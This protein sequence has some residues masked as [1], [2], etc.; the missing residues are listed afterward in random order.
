MNDHIYHREEEPETDNE[1]ENDS[2]SE[3]EADYDEKT[4]YNDNRIHNELENLV[5]AIKSG[6]IEPSEEKFKHSGSLST[7][8]TGQS[9]ST[10]ECILHFLVKETVRSSER[11]RMAQAIRCIAHYQPQLLTVYSEARQTALYLA[12]ENMNTHRAHVILYGLLKREKMEPRLRRKDLQEAIGKKCGPND[13]N[14]LH[15]ALR[16]SPLQINLGILERL[17]SFAPATAINATDSTGI[18]PLHRAVKYELSSAKML[19]IIRNLLKRGEADSEKGDADARRYAFDA[20]YNVGTESLSAYEYH[21]KTRDEFLFKR[22]EPPI[23]PKEKIYKQREPPKSSISIQDGLQWNDGQSR[24]NEEAKN[25]SSGQSKN[26]RSSVKRDNIHQS[27]NVPS[28]EANGQKDDTPDLGIQRS[29]TG[30][31]TPSVPPAAEKSG[32]TERPKHSAG[33]PDEGD[34]KKWSEEICKALKLHCLRTRTIAQAKQFLYG[35][36]KDGKYEP[37]DLGN[38]VDFSG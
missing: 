28:K 17:V 12:L 27:A 15:R 19:E 4:V 36:K 14:C 5:S 30:K 23:R 2:I 35:T 22:S 38:Y 37:I 25:W 29:N 21:L 20:R 7:I 34:L 26:Q 6:E 32:E 1:T 11:A 10:K 24:G 13:E 3:S 16:V 31:Q 18:T 33:K 9:E 8:I